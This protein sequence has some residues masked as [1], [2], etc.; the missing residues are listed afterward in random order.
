MTGPLAE[1]DLA[2]LTLFT[3]G[4]FI[5]VSATVLVCAHLPV[6]ADGVPH[7]GLTRLLG[8]LVA[9]AAA[10]LLSAA[11][12]VAAGGLPI[13][14]AIIVVGLATLWAPWLADLL[15]RGVRDST[16]GLVISAAL[17]VMTVALLNPS[18]L[19]L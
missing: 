1:L 12:F 13:A 19:A 18:F 14:L 17:C 7:L 4:A 11:L 2:L 15:P 9:A 16:V 8:L 6:R 3:A 5:A 10:L